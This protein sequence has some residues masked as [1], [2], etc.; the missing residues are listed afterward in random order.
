[1]FSKGAILDGLGGDVGTLAFVGKKE[2][3]A[4]LVTDIAS[5]HNKPTPQVHVVRKPIVVI[6]STG[7]E[8]VDLH[9]GQETSNESWGGIWD[10]NRPSLQT[11]LEGLGYH[12]IDLGIV[13]D[14][15]ALIFFECLFVPHSS[16]SV[17]DHVAKIQ[18]GLDPADL[19][20]GGTSMGPADL[21]QPVI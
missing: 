1:V 15:L 17:K 6:L 5:P 19:M 7:N 2:V 12:V 10:T 3:H 4:D 9:G 11:A 14:K 8:I 21:L 13:H 18:E 20:T 16:S